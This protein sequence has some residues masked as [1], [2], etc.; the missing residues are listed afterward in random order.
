MPEKKIVIRFN[1]SNDSA[2]AS[3]SKKT[4]PRLIT[5]WNIKRILIALLVLVLCSSA[6]IYLVSPENGSDDL[7]T[8]GV[9]A[10]VVELAI[11]SPPNTARRP[12]N[13]ELVDV[14]KKNK[15]E[16]VLSQPRIQKQP[17]KSHS[18]AIKQAD[19]PAQKVKGQHKTAS[20]VVRATLS[21]KISN[22]EPAGIEI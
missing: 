4:E 1:Y 20:V 14:K 5:E 17:S 19:Q 2:A 8:T 7:T 15:K 18:N 21:R 16:I 13:D 11:P 3:G 9:D 6:L 12:S 22:R 10:T